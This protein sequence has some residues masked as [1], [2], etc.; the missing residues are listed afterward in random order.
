MRDWKYH[1]WLTSRRRVT[2]FTAVGTLACIAVAFAI[3]SY[4]IT[5]GRWAWGED[6]WK[7]VI[8][9]L[10]IA[11]P[12]LYILLTQMRELSIARDRLEVIASTDSLTSCLNRAAFATLVEGY[13]ER[14]AGSPS[15]HGALLVVDVDHFKK[16]N[17]TLGHHVGDEVL[18][19][20]ASTIRNALRDTDLIGRLGGEEF[21][22]FLPGTRPDQCAEIA[23][24]VR[25]AVQ[26][27][28]FRPEGSPL[29]L[30]V[31]IGAAP[32]ATA[33][34]FSELY[35]VADQHLYDAKRTGRNRVAIATLL[36]GTTSRQVQ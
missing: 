34:T 21:S 11:P 30:T 31:S 3:D 22:V 12:T 25:L 13:L 15:N 24:R 7:N 14:F 4:S 26:Q 9:P 1:R 35:Q 32:F 19:M 2:I 8:I 36:D 6:P 28:N 5:Q 10:V 23:E 18:K 16:I 20:I 27:A 17:D 33:T 29:L